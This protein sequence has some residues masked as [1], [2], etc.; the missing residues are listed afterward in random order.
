MKKV[1]KLEKL[2][3]RKYSWNT[4]YWL[5]YC[6][7]NLKDENEALESTWL[8]L[9]EKIKY[10][11]QDVITLPRNGLLDIALGNLHH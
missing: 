11:W 9:H 6:D 2:E 10:D 1:F 5:S 7:W 8:I 3:V 4:E